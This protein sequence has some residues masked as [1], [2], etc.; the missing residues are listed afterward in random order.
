MN[1]E[2]IKSIKPF[3]SELHSK[4]DKLFYNID[5]KNKDFNYSD[6]SLIIK[7]NRDL[8]EVGLLIYKINNNMIKKNRI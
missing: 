1:K 3:F 8:L 6:L 4:I 7:L 2:V 5:K